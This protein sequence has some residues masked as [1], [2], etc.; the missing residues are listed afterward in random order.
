MSIRVESTWK[1]VRRGMSVRF[2]GNLLLPQKNRN[3]LER[4]GVEEERAF[5]F[6]WTGLPCCVAPTL[7]L[8]VGKI[9]PDFWIC[10]WGG[11]LGAGAHASQLHVLNGVCG[12]FSNRSFAL[13]HNPLL[14]PIKF[15]AEKSPLSLK[16]YCS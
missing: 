8:G 1:G 3:V 7:S 9:E 4:P 5:F 6:F 10:S 12:H 2:R 11:G 14:T 16:F 13:F 15:Y